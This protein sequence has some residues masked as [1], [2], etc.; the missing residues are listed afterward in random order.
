MFTPSYLLFLFTRKCPSFLPIRN[1]ELSDYLIDSPWIS[2]LENID[3]RFSL[4][5][6]SIF[7]T[8]CAITQLDR[9]TS[10]FVP[11]GHRLY[12]TATMGLFI[13]PPSSVK[14]A[15]Q[16]GQKIDL[17]DQGSDRSSPWSK[18]RREYDE[19]LES[20][21][22]STKNYIHLR[23]MKQEKIPDI[24]RPS[25][26]K[27]CES[28][29]LP[30]ENIPGSQCTPLRLSGQICDRASSRETTSK[31]YCHSSNPAHTKRFLTIWGF[32]VPMKLLVLKIQK[33]K[34]NMKTG[35]SE[36]AFVGPLW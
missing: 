15:M 30:Q 3:S 9:D 22:R 28:S 1:V 27:S 11:S 8:M 23:P 17:W 25:R 13:V 10:I 20:V 12:L 32:S 7:N 4:E 33:M 35:S 26:S 21:S 18:L 19:S 31:D 34:T 16:D 29:G 5:L 24:L 6:Q 36:R 2:H 14:L